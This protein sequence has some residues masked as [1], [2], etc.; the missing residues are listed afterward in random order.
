MPQ[1][2]P[3]KSAPLS[4]NKPTPPIPP[5]DDSNYVGVQ[6]GRSVS[7]ALPTNPRNNRKRQVLVEDRGSLARLSTLFES[8]D[9]PEL[10]SPMDIECR[11]SITR[12]ARSTSEKIRQ[13]TGSDDALAFHNAKQALINLPWFLRPSYP[14]DH[15]I[16][17]KDFNVRAGTLNALVERLTADHLSADSFQLDHPLLTA[18]LP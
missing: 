12:T 6:R 17:D 9:L 14:P 13:I 8:G 4:V 2:P 10:D 1:P 3:S 18:E 5:G 7:D 16:M 11:P 15:I